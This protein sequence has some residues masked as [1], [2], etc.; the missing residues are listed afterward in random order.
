[1]ANPQLAN[2]ATSFFLAIVGYMGAA[3][4]LHFAYIRFFWLVMGLAG[5]TYQIS[6]TEEAS[7]TK[8][9]PQT[10]T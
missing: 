2:L 1:V 6:Q 4:F 10:Y 8:A 7:V 3:V 9:W 5:A